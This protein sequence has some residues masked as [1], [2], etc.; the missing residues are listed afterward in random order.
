MKP[1]VGRRV[2][3][4]LARASHHERC[5]H[6]VGHGEADDPPAREIETGGQIQP[7]LVGADVGDVAEVDAVEGNAIGIEGATQAIDHGRVRLR[8]GDGGPDLAPSGTAGET[9]LGH[10]AGDTLSPD[11]RSFAGQGGGDPGRAVCGSAL[12]VDL[13]DPLGELR[14]GEG[15][16]ARAWWCQP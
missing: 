10:K 7:A 2:F 11:A 1:G 16:R 4:G 8:I 9:P 15:T 12:G 6:V 3:D 14:I 13:D 5:P